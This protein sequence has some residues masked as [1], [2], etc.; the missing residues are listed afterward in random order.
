V[1]TEVTPVTASEELW[2]LADSDSESNSEWHDATYDV[3]DPFPCHRSYLHQVTHHMSQSEAHQP[4][5][6]Q[7]GH[8]LEAGVMDVAQHGPSASEHGAVEQGE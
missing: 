6:R 5:P 8:E 3:I 7:H 1:G 4:Q 2:A